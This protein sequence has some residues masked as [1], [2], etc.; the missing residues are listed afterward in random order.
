MSYLRITTHLSG[1]PDFLKMSVLRITLQNLP[2]L[3][4]RAQFCYNRTNK[5]ERRSEMNLDEYRAHVEAQRKES[6]LKAMAT[7]SDCSNPTKN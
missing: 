7:I 4:L 6:L 3:D 2:I 1:S 5:N